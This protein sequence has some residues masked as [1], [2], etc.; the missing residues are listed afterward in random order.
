MQFVDWWQFDSYFPNAQDVESVAISVKG[1]D[2]PLYE[3]TEDDANAELRMEKMVLSGNAKAES[4]EWLKT[5]AEN[6]TQ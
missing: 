1:V 4:L 3:E 6:Q 2:D 5:I